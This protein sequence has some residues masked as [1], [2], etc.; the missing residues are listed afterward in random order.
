MPRVNK[1]VCSKWKKYVIKL[2]YKGIISIDDSS[3]QCTICVVAIGE[4]IGIQSTKE[5]NIK[6]H[7]KKVENNNIVKRQQFVRRKPSNFNCER[8]RRILIRNF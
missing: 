2:G 4:K 7:L 1:S 8:S 6:T 3:L 5:I